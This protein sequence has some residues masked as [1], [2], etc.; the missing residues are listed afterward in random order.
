MFTLTPSETFKATVTVQVATATGGWKTE[1]FVGEFERT[2]DDEREAL[3]ALSNKALVQRVL[4][5]WDMKD[6]KKNP[7]EFN[8]IHKEMFMRLTGALRET[9]L[10][11]WQH[12]A[13]AKAKN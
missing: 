9:M 5:G 7:V 6:E 8:E 12:N 11:Y 13:G 2:D 1:S 4:I 10:V 3:L